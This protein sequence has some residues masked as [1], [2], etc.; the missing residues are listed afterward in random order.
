MQLSEK[1]ER[2]FLWEVLL[3]LGWCKGRWA[4]GVNGDRGRALF[5]D[6]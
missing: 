2:R 3:G 1:E 5:C 4:F 6:R